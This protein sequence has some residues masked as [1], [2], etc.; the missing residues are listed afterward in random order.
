MQHDTGFGLGTSEVKRRHI[1]PKAL[2]VGLVA[3]LLA[4]AF[5]VALAFAE[6]RGVSFLLTLAG[7]MR[8]AVAVGLGA[9]GGAIGL[10]LVRRFAPD[11]S[12]SG[13]PQLKGFVLGECGIEWR[14][15]LP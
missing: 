4:T 1:L 10:W 11:A 12:G 3:G 9:A 8:I 13:I 5:R 6:G 7:P 15:L 14:R 2:V